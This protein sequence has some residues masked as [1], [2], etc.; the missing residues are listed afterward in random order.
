MPV[1]IE[2]FHIFTRSYA[3]LFSVKTDF[4]KTN[5]NFDFKN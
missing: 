1:G 5:N 3:V 2:R 4:Y